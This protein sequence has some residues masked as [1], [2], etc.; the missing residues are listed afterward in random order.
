MTAPTPGY[1]AKFIR[2][3]A[4]LFW[5]FARIWF[6]PRVEGLEQVPPAPCLFICNHSAY[7]VFEILVL[8]ALWN[9]RFGVARPVVGMAHDLGLIRPIRWGVIPIGGVRASHQ[10]ALEALR[11]GYDVLAFPGGFVDALRPFGARYE[12][13]WGR[14][15]GF[16]RV[17][18]EAGAPVVPLVN[19]GSHAQYTLLRGGTG[20][21]RVLRLTRVRIRTWPVP[22][23]F[24]GLLA[25]GLGAALGAFSGWWILA[26]AASAFI[27][28]P[29]RMDVK[30]LKAVDVRM[31]LAASSESF[32]QTAEDIRRQMTKE[33]EELSQRRLTPWE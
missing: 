22:L 21:A 18:A 8:L 20:L 31:P 9:R 29:T 23:G 25:A 33:L 19:C 30:F 32:S 1:S 24:F 11:R 3:F 16:V 7:G 12:V 4:A 28:N 10:A 6:R 17:A 5:P 2:R 14:R 15:A 26:A 13:H 27:P